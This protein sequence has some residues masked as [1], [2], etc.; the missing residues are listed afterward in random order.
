M[1][2]N[3]ERGARNESNEINEHQLEQERRRYQRKNIM[4]VRERISVGLRNIH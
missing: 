3:L 1:K 4:I 2:E